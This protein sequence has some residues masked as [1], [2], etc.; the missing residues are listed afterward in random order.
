MYD[1]DKYV[2]VYVC[3]I[4]ACVCVNKYV[5]YLEKYYCYI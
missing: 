5:L 2:C 4:Y 1:I 3:I